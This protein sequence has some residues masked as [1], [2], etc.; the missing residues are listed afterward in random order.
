MM[1]RTLVITSFLLF[2]FGESFSYAQNIVYAH[3]VL[4]TLCS[5]TM[6][7]R[8]CN[9]RGDSLAAGFIAGE[10]KKHGLLSFTENYKQSY[11]LPC[12]EIKSV[13]CAFSHPDS[14][15]QGGEEYVVYG[16][17]PSVSLLLK[18]EKPVF[19]SRPG[20][21]DNY[22]KKEKLQDKVLVFNSETFSSSILYRQV[23]PELSKQDIV[24][25][26]I[27]AQNNSGKKLMFPIGRNKIQFPVLLLKDKLIVK[28]RIEYLKLDIESEFH[29]NYPTQNVVAYVEG[30]RQ[31]DSFFVFVSHYDHL[32]GM[33]DEVYFPGAND[34]ASSVC[35]LL[36][37]SSYYAKPENQ[38]D[39]SVLFIATSGEELGLL[40]SGYYA[41]N[42]YFP[43]SDIKFLI[44]MD[45]NGTGSGGFHLVH[46]LLEEKASAFIEKKNAENYYFPRI[47]KGGEAANSDHYPFYR[48]SVPCLFVFTSG[49]EFTEYHSIY[50][51]L[52]DLP[53]TKYEQVFRL[54]TDFVRE[55]R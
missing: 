33:G 52:Q 19:F 31:P 42:P 16:S 20:D 30:K 1:K 51:R 6:F 29:P 27:I 13:Y 21:W 49:C 22:H 23:L 32:G 36:D 46:G 47:V 35:L 2:L 28:K 5:K 41:N 24:P 7:G 45:M 40:G 18:D 8:S 11:T 44:N 15:L 50:D 43:L 3:H 54:M 25:K 34:N 14:V 37:L 12:N 55:Y 53:F 48:K 10:F 26:L 17:S 9:K 4:D 38:P 39:Y